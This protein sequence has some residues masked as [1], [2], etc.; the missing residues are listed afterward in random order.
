MEAA[1]IDGCGPIETF[2]HVVL[3]NSLS[4]IFAVGILQFLW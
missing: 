3:P 1:K 4:P 2:R